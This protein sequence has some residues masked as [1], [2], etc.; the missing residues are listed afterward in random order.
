[1]AIGAV[2]QI[3]GGCATGIPEHGVPRTADEFDAAA[4]VYR[5]RSLAVAHRDSAA[6]PERLAVEAVRER[7]RL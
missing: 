6:R 5:G 1:M 3:D 2:V 4:S 7:T